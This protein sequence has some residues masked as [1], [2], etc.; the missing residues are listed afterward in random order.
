MKP[1]LASG[2][3][4]RISFMDSN[5]K[6]TVLGF[7]T[8][9]SISESAG[10]RPS[11]VV[12]SINP[13][14]IEPLSLDVNCSIGRIIPINAQT[15]SALLSNVTSFDYKFQEAIADILGKDHVEII[16]ED[17][18]SANGTPNIIGVVKYARFAGMSINTN[19]GDV[20]SERYNFVGIFDG[21]YK[22]SANGPESINYGL[23]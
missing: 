22:G 9:I 10:L 1:Q 16:L 7:V 12:G 19:A 17:K 18:N 21:G 14:S 2:A 20:S 3:R 8:D 23:E 6:I 5:G 11:Y 15:S 13:V 4:G